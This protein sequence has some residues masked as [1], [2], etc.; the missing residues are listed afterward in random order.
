VTTIMGVYSSDTT[1]A[2]FP[3][4]G[5]TLIEDLQS[6]DIWLVPN[7]GRKVYFSPDATQIAWTEWVLLEGK[8]FLRPVWVSQ[9]DGTGAKEITA[10]Y[11]LGF[12][13][14]FPDG[15]LLVHGRYDYNEEFNAYW[16]VSLEDGSAT[17]LGR[18]FRVSYGAVSPGGRWMAY[19]NVLDPRDEENGLWI[20][21][22]L[23]LERNRLEVFGPFQWR[24]EGILVVIPLEF[25]A[26][27]HRLIEV[28]VEEGTEHSLTDPEA[29]S[30]KIA[31][32]DWAIS[33]D[34]R[35]LAYVSAGDYN[36]WVLELP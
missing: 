9:V 1:K 11:G 25:E 4:K 15:R 16:A 21:D 29:V 24:E 18:G 17:E 20:V 12:A 26:D 31:G 6:G 19:H 32:G 14:W 33:P 22:T 34:G 7:G 27:F 28:D 13:G 8:R 35:W 2:A 3:I 23:T 30:M 10:L 5:Q 36:I